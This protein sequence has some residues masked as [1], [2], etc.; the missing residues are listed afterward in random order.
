MENYDVA[1]IN[2]EFDSNGNPPLKHT[3][4]CE[5]PNYGSVEFV[6]Y[7]VNDGW[8]VKYG[9]YPMVKCSCGA[10]LLLGLGDAV[11][12]RI[13]P[14]TQNDVITI[15]NINDFSIALGVA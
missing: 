12:L 6:F 15:D 7:R 8:I 3:M 5:M 14:N 10:N 13:V 4:T 11:D 2:I 9:D 1:A